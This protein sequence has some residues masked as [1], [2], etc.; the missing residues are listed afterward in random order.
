MTTEMWPAL[1]VSG[2]FFL[3]GAVVFFLRPNQ[4]TSWGI[5]ISHC[6][7]AIFF[8]FPASIYALGAYVFHLGLS[9]FEEPFFFRDKPLRYLLLYA[10]SILITIP[11][12][13]GLREISIF[14]SRIYVGLGIAYLIFHVYYT[15]YAGKDATMRQ[16]AKLLLAGITIS[17]I[18]A[19]FAYRMNL[20]ELS[21]FSTIAIPLAISYGALRLNL[22]EV[23]EIIKRSILYTLTLVV[24]AVIYGLFLWASNIYLEGLIFSQDKIIILAVIIFFLFYFNNLKR[25]VQATLDR[26][27]YRKKANYQKAFEEIRDRLSV[28]MDIE[29]LALT[30]KDLIKKY[31][32]VDTAEVLIA[33]AGHKD[34]ESANGETKLPQE[35]EIIKIAR[36]KNRLV[37]NDEILNDPKLKAVKTIALGQMAKIES[38]FVLPFYYREKMMGIITLGRIQSGVSFN[39]KDL[40]LLDFLANQTGIALEN[41]KLYDSTGRAKRKLQELN[42]EL[43]EKVKERTG[44]LEGRNIELQVANE[45]IK[46]ATQHKAE[47]LSS[48]SHELRTPLNGI[49]GFS[50][51]ILQG[52]YG[53]VTAKIKEILTE[54][55]KNGKKLLQTINNILDFSKI[56]A[57]KMELKTEE[58]SP[59]QVAESAAAEHYPEAET[60][61][62]KII[63]SFEPN[64]PSAKGDAKR[65][66][67]IL[68]NLIENAVN[69]SD[70]GEIKVS[71]SA[72]NNQLFFVVEDNGIGIAKDQAEKIFKRFEEPESYLK[73]SSHG[74]GLGLPISKQLTEMHGGSFSVKSRPGKGAAFSFSIPA[75]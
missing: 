64:L 21:T 20:R 45:K 37:S 51:L 72:K 12:F 14:F 58:F 16:R 41:A 24:I 5:L 17:G 62:L 49:L 28:I 55:K 57:G 19:I 48:M 8:I 65:I 52:I 56:E 38:A 73:K 35:A 46:N 10:I 6:G 39:L 44:E 2:L 15:T 69:F 70:N 36:D 29:M 71:A 75:K 23:D 32:L 40:E 31:L 27:F 61:K 7:L 43:E 4:P 50:D 34:L 13:F 42:L 18:I 68:S 33:N 3:N 47:F 53:E 26:T 67:Q 60:K 30:V 66:K 59:K 74:A 54:L 22:Y 63:T 25:P 9:L 1:I 11:Y